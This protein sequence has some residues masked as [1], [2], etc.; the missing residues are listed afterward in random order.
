MS[1]ITAAEATEEEEKEK[2][3]TGTVAKQKDVFVFAPPC[4]SMC[5]HRDPCLC[6]Q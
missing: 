5:E 6:D 3:Q 1:L 4:V 2:T